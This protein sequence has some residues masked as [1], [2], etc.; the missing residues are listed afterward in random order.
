VFR[1]RSYWVIYQIMDV[2][3]GNGVATGMSFTGCV[4]YIMLGFSRWKENLDRRVYFMSMT[5]FTN[6][7]QEP[8]HMS[9]RS[10]RLLYN[11]APPKSRWPIQY[12]IKALNRIE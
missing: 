1:I 9:M 4:Y 8:L 3:E 2:Y 12:I 11:P 10:R 7:Q 5:C 6:S